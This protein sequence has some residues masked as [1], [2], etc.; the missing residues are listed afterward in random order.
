VESKIK[1]VECKYIEV[2]SKQPKPESKNT[3]QQKI[4]EKGPKR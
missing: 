1:K 3:L 4:R 2:E